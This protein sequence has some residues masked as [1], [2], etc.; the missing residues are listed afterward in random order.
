MGGA[1]PGSTLASLTNNMNPSVPQ[2]RTD[3]CPHL[4]TTADPQTVLDYP[5]SQNC[6]HRAVPPA[7]PGVDHQR[8]FC[9]VSGHIGCPLCAVESGRAPAGIFTRRS[10]GIPGRV[11]MLHRLLPALALLA[12]V[13]AAV[14]LALARVSAAAPVRETQPGF[15]LPPSASPLPAVQ[16]S[17]N[18]VPILAAQPTASP[19]AQP[20]LTARP[21]ATPSPTPRPPHLLETPLGDDRQFLL[22]RTLPG[23]S[24]ELIASSYLT[25][26]AALRA[27]NY[28]LPDALWVDAVL[29]VPVGQT[30]PA[31][32]VPMSAFAAGEQG[33]TLAAVALEQGVSLAELCALNGLASDEK[34]SP[35][36]WVIVSHPPAP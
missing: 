12:V 11:F 17:L 10:A 30:D 3:I 29:V 21:S 35:G 22:H 27:A 28:N 25:T 18:T 5:T 31:G 26:I 36:E 33:A 34:I 16:P 6:C 20:S 15:A 23:E 32:I 9:L 2:S 1:Y 4:G 24:Y 8:E 13:A 7:S 19:S 14:W